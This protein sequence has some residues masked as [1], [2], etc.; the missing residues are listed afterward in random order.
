[1]WVLYLCTRYI[2]VTRPLQ[3]LLACVC[4]FLPINHRCYECPHGDRIHDDVTWFMYYIIFYSIGRKRAEKPILVWKYNN[5]QIGETIRVVCGER[6][7]D[8][9]DTR[10]YVG[11][12]R[13]ERLRLVV[14][15]IRTYIIINIIMLLG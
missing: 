1:M 5:L 12:T 3:I 15:C 14:R 4:R 10:T 9:W 2:G 13:G 11:T 7:I 8:K 6:R